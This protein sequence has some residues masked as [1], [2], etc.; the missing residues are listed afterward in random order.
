MDKPFE[1]INDFCE[2][3]KAD[4]TVVLTCNPTS[5][6]LGC[7]EESLKNILP[8]IFMVYLVGLKTDS[9]SILGFQLKSLII[10]DIKPGDSQAKQA[11]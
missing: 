7:R 1:S 6:F 8:G 3:K 11:V 10:L 9:L 4:W 5:Q 2:P